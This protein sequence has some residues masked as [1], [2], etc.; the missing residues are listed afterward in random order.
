[1]ARRDEGFTLIEI[2][3]ALAVLGVGLF[4]LME[5][6]F[7]SLNLYATAE[8]AAVLDLLVSEAMGIAEFE[9]LSGEES[10]KGDFGDV[11]PDYAYTF[12]STQRDPEETP[13]LFDVQLTMTG[14]EEE[15]VLMFLVYDGLQVE[16]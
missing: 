16:L 11:Y 3:V 4:V 8:D 10:G 13:G 12:I 2:V 1:M 15:K 9:V 14:F 7:A 5:S 6:H